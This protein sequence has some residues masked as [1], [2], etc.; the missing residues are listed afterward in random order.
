MIRTVRNADE[1]PALRWTIG[2]SCPGLV[3]RRI[4]V[5]PR[6]C[7]QALCNTS[8][9]FRVPHSEWPAR[10]VILHWSPACKLSGNIRQNAEAAQ[11]TTDLLLVL[12]NG[13][14]RYMPIIATLVIAN[15]P[16]FAVV[17]IG[18]RVRLRTSGDPLIQAGIQ[19]DRLF[20][21][22]QSLLCGSFF[23]KD[24]EFSRGYCPMKS[25]RNYHRRADE[26]LA[27]AMM[28]RDDEERK[29][30]GHPE[31]HCG[32]ARTQSEIFDSW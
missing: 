10:I 11:I 28:A 30:G 13:P 29:R 20:R 4:A 32:Q 26:C 15:E 27:F 12:T 9:T 18:I 14:R 6:S 3:E 24:S 1:A 8:D 17:G 31:R 25:Q 22:G 7:P 23:F 16:Q 2:G 5:R 19:D 21:P